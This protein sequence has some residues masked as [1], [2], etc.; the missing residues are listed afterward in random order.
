MPQEKRTWTYEEIE[1]RVKEIL[2]DSLGVPKEQIERST[3]LVDLMDGGDVCCPCF[4]RS[5]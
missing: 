5:Q 1:D 4:G 3:K 2:S